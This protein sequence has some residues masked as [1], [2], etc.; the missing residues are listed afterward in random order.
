MINKFDSGS[1][2]TVEPN[3]LTIGDYWSWK[4]PDISST[5][6]TDLY[7]IRYQFY[8]QS[9]D[10]TRFEV[11]ANKID[12]Q[13]VVEVS[14]A[15]SINY[16]NGE[17]V[18]NIVAVRDLDGEQVNIATGRIIFKPA[19]H[20]DGGDLRS[21]ARKVLDAIKA[22]IEKT[23]TK[24]QASY[25]IAGRSLARRTIDELLMLRREYDKLVARENAAL[26]RKQGKPS[27]KKVLIKMSA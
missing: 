17:Y 12:G 11:A 19:L 14:S 2:A 3:E 22:T 7:T 21:H 16:K 6:T 13:H 18:Y 26:A 23:A 8:L 1:L 4:R 15:L 27:K 9:N 24:E 25:T 5:Y 10:G 20:A